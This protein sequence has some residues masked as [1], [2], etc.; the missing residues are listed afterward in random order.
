MFVAKF[1]NL[2]FFDFLLN[3]FG[4]KIN[5]KT[6][7]PLTITI[8][9]FAFIYVISQNISESTIREIVKNAGPFGVTVLI[10]L[11]WLTNIFAP[12]GAAPFIYAGFYLYGP[13]VTIYS[14]IAAFIAS[15]TNYWIARIW[16][17][18]LVIKLVGEDSLKKLNKFAKTYGLKTLFITRI[19][20]G[21]FHDVISYMFGLTNIKFYP[22]I[23]VSTLGTI[24]GSLLW[25]FIATKTNN[26][27]TFM[28]VTVI[29]TYGFLASYF[30]WI[31]LT[32]KDQTPAI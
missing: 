28:T 9:L 8:L 14:Y 6:L 21:Q 7:L 1:V 31:K 27:V 5:R 18:A 25:F 26:P 32:K 3:F 24:P 23:I 17:E 16:G 13:K 10:F 11:V 12:L 20:L 29:I 22:Y 30:L 15:I 19:F 4:M 2:I